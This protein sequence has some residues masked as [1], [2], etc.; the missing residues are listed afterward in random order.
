[1]RSDRDP[2]IFWVA[3]QA[4]MQMKERHQNQVILV[5]G[6][7]GAGK[8]ENTKLMIK[9]LTHICKN[10]GQGSECLRDRIVKVCVHSVDRSVVQ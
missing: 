6:E 3:D 7:S 2:H 1:M 10:A 8:T 4:Y 5:S 9:H